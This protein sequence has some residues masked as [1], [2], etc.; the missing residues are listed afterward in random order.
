VPYATSENQNIGIGSIELYDAIKKEFPDFE[1]AAYLNGT[2]D[3][4]SIKWLL[5]TRL[6]NKREILGYLGPKFAQLVQI[7]HHFKWGKYLAYPKRWVLETGRSLLLLFPLDATLRKALLNFIKNPIHLFRK[8]YLQSIMFIQPI[9]MM[10]DGSPNMC[11][12]C[13]DVSLWNGQLV[14]S[15]RLEEPLKFGCFVRAV[16]RQKSPVFPGSI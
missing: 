12:S 5:T 11:D 16:P 7:F 15:C 8:V 13:P 10:P 1:S 4:T 14:W 6:G 2:A 9:D 3:P